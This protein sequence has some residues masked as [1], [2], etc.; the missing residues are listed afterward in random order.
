M[1]YTQAQKEATYKWRENNKEHFK[2]LHKKE[3]KTYYEKH[4]EDKIKK[5]LERYYINKEKATI[6]NI[7]MN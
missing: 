1:A 3:A 4:K 7:M 5:V 2:E 6:F